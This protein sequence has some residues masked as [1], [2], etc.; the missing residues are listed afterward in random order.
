[1]LLTNQ[2][3]EEVEEIKGSL[4]IRPMNGISSLREVTIMKT[5]YRLAMKTKQDE[6]WDRTKCF[7]E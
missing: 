5:G 2:C 4:L 1:M 6:K 7:D 3:V